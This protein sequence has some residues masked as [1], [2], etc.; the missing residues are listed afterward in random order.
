[1]AVEDAVYGGVTPVQPVQPVPATA[2]VVLPVSICIAK[3]WLPT[4]TWAVYSKS[5]PPGACSGMASPL[6]PLDE[7]LPEDEPLLDEEPLDEPLLDDEPLDE[8]L[9]D[10]EPPLDEPLPDDEPPSEPVCTPPSPLPNPPEFDEFVEPHAPIATPPSM[11]ARSFPA[12]CMRRKLV[13]SSM[14]ARE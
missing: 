8:P 2:A 12:E 5:A 10:D 6:A 11:I 13:A 4:V 14:E 1:L 7:P 3:V 9:P